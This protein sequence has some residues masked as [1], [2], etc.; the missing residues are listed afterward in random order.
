MTPDA[1]RATV[2]V[3]WEGGRRFRAGRPG[4]ALLLLDG[5]HEAAPSPVEAMVSALGAC[6]AIDVVDILEKRRTPA[7]ELS[8]RVDYE[9][10][11]DHPRRLVAATLRFHVAT[12]ADMTH[13]E[14]AVSLSIDKYCSVAASLAP[15]TRISWSVEIRAP[16]S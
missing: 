8:V 2:D 7:S 13:V 15:D 11:D 12:E 3:E 14:R 16:E 9:R 4:G 10:V 5:D 6:S 1:N